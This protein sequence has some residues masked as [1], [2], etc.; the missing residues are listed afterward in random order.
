MLLD[1]PRVSRT[2]AATGVAAT[3][4]AINHRKNA[5][6]T[7]LAVLNTRRSVSVGILPWR[8]SESLDQPEIGKAMQVPKYGI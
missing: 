4:V 5:V 8:C 2:T 6:Q 1:N 7:K 3:G